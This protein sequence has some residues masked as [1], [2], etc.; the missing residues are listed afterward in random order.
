M[1]YIIIILF[2]T[3]VCTY[4]LYDLLGWKSR[5]KSTKKCKKKI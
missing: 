2:S 1:N 3:L 5:G 4:C